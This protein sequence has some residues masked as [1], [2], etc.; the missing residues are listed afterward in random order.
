MKNILAK[1]SLTLLA[2][3]V[4]CAFSSSA[5]GAATIVIQ[6]ADN[7]NVGFNDPTAVA[8]VGGNPG[9]TLGQQ[10]LNAFQFAANIWGASLNS[11]TT[12][13]IRANWEPLDCTS[14]TA[15]L[16]SAGANTIWRDFSGATFPSTWYSAA[17]AN[18]LTGV[19]LQ[20][21]SPEITARFNISL[22]QP[23]CGDTFPFYLGLDN[24]HGSGTDLVAV[25]L[26][27][28]SHGFGFQ[29]FTNASTGAQNG[30]FASIYDRFLFDNSTN[31]NWVQ[32]TNAERAASAINTTHLTWNGP[33]VTGQ[34]TSVLATPRLRVNSPA[35]IAGNYQVGTAGF[36]SPL[37]SAGT[38]A[39]V[40]QALD[41]SDGAGAATTDGCSA[42]TNA[43]AV[44]GKIALI[45]RGTCTF[46]VKVKNAQNAGAVAVIIADNVAGSPP[47]GLGGSDPTI[48]IPS[49]RITLADGNTIKAQLGSGVNASLIL[50][51]SV[52]GGADA[53]GRALMYAPNPL[54]GGSSVSHW[55]TTLY[56]NQLMEPNISGDLTHNV[57]TP[58]DLTASL[59]RDIGWV[60][61]ASSHAN[62][63][64]FSASSQSV[65][66]TLDQTTRIDLTVN[67]SGDTTGAATIDYASADGTASERSDYMAARGTLFFNAG[68]TSKTIP[69]FIVDDR[70]GETPETFTVGLSNPVGCT[71][72]SQTTFTVTIN[73]NES[74][75]GGNP[76]KDATF[77]TDFFVRQHYLDFFN[78]EPDTGGLNFWKDQIDSCGADTTCKD[79]RKINVSAAFFLSIEFQQTGYLVERLY[80]TAYGSATGNSTL[81]GT[82]H[83]LPVPIVRLN[84]FL[85]DTQQIGRGVVIGQ[86]GADQQLETNKQTLI[87]QFVQR[88]RFLTA[89]PGSMTPAQFVDTLNSNAGFPLS[90]AE[91]DQLVTDLTAGTKTRAQVL[92]AVAEDSDL[93]NLEQ[94]RAFVLAQFFGY[95]RRN[96]NDSPDPDYSGYDFW[97]GKLNQF[98]GNFVN[99]DMVK[100][101]LVS[102]EYQQR[103]GP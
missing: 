45:D 15:V 85:P 17:L 83:T 79:L 43:G 39:A 54:E 11:T 22:G 63:V 57:D 67:R 28:F 71:L 91:R 1:F 90:Q 26:H 103:F 86:P 2:A 41:P 27:E 78:R 23:G 53:Q 58:L 66:E 31:K 89:F 30:G 70:F 69:I 34:T 16:G 14:T 56:P 97:L 61:T 50:D 55:D 64:D 100:S 60:I 21:G 96:P 7:P 59:L 82:P 20:A 18:A 95:L 51:H 88:Q 35:G 5:F 24:N 102:G 74:V 99:A 13:T 62:S 42:L 75:N 12:I 6:N 10:R 93:F 19:D 87:A 36:G 4:V 9:T 40:V 65:S 37:T 48:S 81:G 29:T 46:V 38:T 101:F 92:R 80:K 76:V 3:L 47:P 8:P 73:S 98:N 32:M 77:N 94:N 49:V 72:G 84:E 68:E 52:P 44:S 25:L 33:T